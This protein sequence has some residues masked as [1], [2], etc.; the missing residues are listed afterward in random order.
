MQSSHIMSFDAY[1]L[2][3]VAGDAASKVTDIKDL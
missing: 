2:N 1:V 3:G